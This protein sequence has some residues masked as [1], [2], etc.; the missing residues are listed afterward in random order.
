VIQV[1]DVARPPERKSKPNKAEL[2]VITALAAGFLL[3]LFVFIR[4]ALRQAG[5]DLERRE[6]LSRLS[7]A[8]SKAIGR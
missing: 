2:A 1:L 6:K 4:N 5:S 7:R 3:L 8:W